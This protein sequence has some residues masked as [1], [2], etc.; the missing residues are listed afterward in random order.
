MNETSDATAIFAPVW[1]RKWLILAVGALVAAGTYFY[2][3]HQPSEY[4]AA[5]Q[6]YLGGGSEVQS[7]LTGAA[8][9]SPESERAIAD[10]AE[11]I[12]SNLIGEAVRRQLLHEHSA[13][14]AEGLAE[15]T[16]SREVDFITI[17]T[18]AGTGP[19]AAQLA[20]TYASVYL[21][22]ADATYRRDLQL[23]LANTRQQL[24]SA[25]AASH[26]GSQSVASQTL[27]E[28]IS[29]LQSEL[30]V[31]NPG[32]KQIN[33]AVASATPLSPDPT[34]NAIFGFVI[35]IALAAI[36][37]YTLSRLDRRL[38]SLVDVE[39]AF[40]TEI[41][42]A[43]PSVR[44]PITH[45][46]GELALAEP[47][48]E[49]LRRLHTVLQLRER[50]LGGEN[51]RDLPR[52]IM[53][54][55]AE[56]GDGKSMLVA[57]LGLVQR[58]AGER[59]AVVDADLRRPVQSQLFGLAGSQGL[60]EVLAGRL[61]LGDAI[62]EVNSMSPPS[63]NGAVTSAEGVA[64]VVG[65]RRVGSLAVLA[66]GGAVANPPALLAEPTMPRLL[67]SVA[68]DFDWVLIDAPPPLEV[69]DVMPLLHL[70][71]AI[72]VVARIGQTRQASAKRLV[73]LLSRGTK[74][75]VL[76]VVAN[77]VP[78]EELEGHGFS[79]AYY[80]PRARHR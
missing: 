23:L 30:S 51:H 55:S 16:S 50:E 63:T 54:L 75:P 62:Q 35:G 44:R 32:N 80:Q 2:Y 73:E 43:L 78:I 42:A 48:R 56:A 60:V 74:A 7:L 46:E 25:Q 70:V 29:A 57:G 58:E 47:L 79:S 15:A 3:R 65:S 34:R 5:T 61:A 1:R 36:A 17:T 27:S 21:R 22:E 38:R 76:G 6:I 72:V 67:R 14:A 20:N 37:A 28:R 10:Q 31:G 77:D 40:Q 59:V 8:A 33:P 53:F 26:G 39:E 4:G 69:S 19:A 9:S 24:S 45:R 11:L 12:N 52:S 68:D 18:R 41:L 64:T 66:S 13:S 71:D 49:P